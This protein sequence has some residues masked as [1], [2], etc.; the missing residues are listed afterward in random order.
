MRSRCCS[1][2]FPPISLFFSTVVF[3]VG[4]AHVPCSCLCLCLNGEGELVYKRE[5]WQC[6]RWCLFT[7][8]ECNNILSTILMFMFY[9]AISL[10]HLKEELNVISSRELFPKVWKIQKNVLS[11]ML[12]IWWVMCVS[13][14]S[15]P[16]AE[17]WKCFFT[18]ESN[19]AIYIKV[20]SQ[21]AFCLRGTVSWADLSFCCNRC[22]ACVYK[23]N[24]CWLWALK[25]H[26][27]FSCW[28]MHVAGS[29][30]S[31]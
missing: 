13:Q 18:Y 8:L 21:R 23:S 5:S 6:C 2:L 19:I 4:V 14:G 3:C 25:R 16:D 15:S 17:L 28:C 26:F 29:R 20:P 27:G 24:W 31:R 9:F 1:Y 12:H 22:T 30:I 11:W 10:N 7:C